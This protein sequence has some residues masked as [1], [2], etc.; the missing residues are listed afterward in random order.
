MDKSKLV[1]VDSGELDE[2]RPV[3]TRTIDISDFVELSEVD[4]AYCQRTYWLAPDG[5]GAARAY[6]LLLAAMKDRGKAGSAGRDAQQAVPH[7]HSRPVTERW[8]CVRCAS[9]TR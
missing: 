7:G 5:E 8:P 3:T 4:A 9:P 1:V 6:R 2:L